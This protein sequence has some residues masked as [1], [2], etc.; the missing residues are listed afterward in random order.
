MQSIN[1]THDSTRIMKKG[2][3][4]K[5]TDPLGSYTLFHATLFHQQLGKEVDVNCPRYADP[6]TFSIR[7]ALP[8]QEQERR[9]KSRMKCCRVTRIGNT[10]KTYLV[11]EN[12]SLSYALDRFLESITKYASV[13]EHILHL[14]TTER[15]KTT[16]YLSC[17]YRQQMWITTPLLSRG[18]KF[19]MQDS[20][21]KCGSVVRQRNWRSTSVNWF[22]SK[23]FKASKLDRLH[24]DQSRESKRSPVFRHTITISCWYQQ[25]LLFLSSRVHGLHWKFSR[26]AASVS[27][28]KIRAA[29]CH[30]FASCHCCHDGFTQLYASFSMFTINADNCL[31]KCSC[32]QVCS[33]VTSSIIDSSPSFWNEVYDPYLQCCCGTEAETDFIPTS[34]YFFAVGIFL[35]LRCPSSTRSCVQKYRTSMCFVRC[36]ALPIDPIEFVVE[37][38]LMHF[39]HHCDSQILIQWFQG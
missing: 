14:I 16:V 22:S 36:P 3:R 32:L 34:A 7:H 8:C 38:S 28:H 29:Y 25:Y 24:L 6:T 20:W 23:Q 33:P 31:F 12:D 30:C 35:T 15:R 26:S 21:A 13:Q 27:V 37:L 2:R 11:K 39:N 4:S 18:M 19:M 10:Q 9:F 5:S 17:H 1:H